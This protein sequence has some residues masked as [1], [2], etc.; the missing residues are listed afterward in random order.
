MGGRE[1]DQHTL[2]ANPADA[3][4]LRRAAVRIADQIAAEHPHPLDDVM[5]RLAGRQL[6]HD[7]AAAASLL[8]LLDAI[9]YTR[10]EQQ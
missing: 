9:G 2:A 5:P 3:R 1:L 7:P 8:E 10:K 4:I 6:A